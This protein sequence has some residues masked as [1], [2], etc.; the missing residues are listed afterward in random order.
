MTV[1]CRRCISPQLR[2]TCPS[3]NLAARECKVEADLVQPAYCCGVRGLACGA[4]RVVVVVS[5]GC[6][7][8]VAVGNKTTVLLGGML[9]APLHFV[10]HRSGCSWVAESDSS[11]D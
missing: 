7:I 10:P 4:I 5:V 1:L 9:A 11:S 8:A 6:K 2:V 3:W